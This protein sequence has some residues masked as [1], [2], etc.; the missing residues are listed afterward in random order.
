MAM[1]PI[2]PLELLDTPQAA[3]R[4]GFAPDTFVKWRKSGK[5]PPYV[6]IA[7]RCVRYRVCDLEV[8]LTQ[9]TV[10]PTGKKAHKPITG[11][12]APASMQQEYRRALHPHLRGF[13]SRGRA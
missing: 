2:D 8:W 3:A 11:R 7:G 5:G 1:L 4:Y 13:S 6:K 10:R 9:N 12:P